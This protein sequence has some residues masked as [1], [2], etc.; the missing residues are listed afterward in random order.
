MVVGERRYRFKPIVQGAAGSLPI[1]I[2]LG[3]E[4]MLWRHSA[5]Q[6]TAREAKEQFKMGAVGA[7]KLNIRGETILDPLDFNQQLFTFS[8]VTFNGEEKAQIISA[9]FLT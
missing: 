1:H 9:A 5:A 3:R 6:R 7:L 4:A 8:P 2:H